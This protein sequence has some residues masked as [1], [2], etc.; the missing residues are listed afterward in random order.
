MVLNGRMADGQGVVR[1]Y[2]EVAVSSPK[3]ENSNGLTPKL[4]SDPVNRSVKPLNCS[5][6]AIVSTDWW[7]GY[8]ID[9]ATKNK[10]QT[11]LQ[12]LKSVFLLI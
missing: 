1:V 5:R 12:P 11:A 8:S 7:H 4:P 2:I 3:I 10:A 9:E 6:R